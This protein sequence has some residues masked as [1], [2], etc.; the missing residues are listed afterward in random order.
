[1]V[2]SYGLVV[3]IVYQLREK[4]LMM[5]SIRLLL[6]A[7]RTKGAREYRIGTVLEQVFRCAKNLEDLQIVNIAPT[8]KASMI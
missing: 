6:I 8:S 5:T 1:M 7:T 4:K 3:Q 2:T